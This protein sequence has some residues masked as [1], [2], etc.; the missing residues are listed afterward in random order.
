MS[1]PFIGEIKMLASN[2]APR[3]YAMCYG[4]LLPIAQNNALFAL[5]GTA[6]GGDGRTTFGLPHFG[7]RSPIGQGAAAPGVPSVYQ[8]GEAGG[9]ESTTLLQSNMPMHQHLHKVSTSPATTDKPDANSY[10]AA[11]VD[12]SGN[13]V[14][15]Y[16]TDISA[17]TTLAPQSIV[18]TGGS[19]AFDIRNPYLAV[20]FVIALVGEYPSR[21]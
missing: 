15:I 9:K 4:Q 14:N 6:Y 21:N 7:G 8:L 13:A 1:D 20:S 16:G 11:A 12:G 18:P 10:L 19:Q 2:Y 5:V 3:G 17:P